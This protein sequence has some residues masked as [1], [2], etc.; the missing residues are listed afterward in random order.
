M[1]DVRI[2][3]ELLVGESTYS[4]V[5]AF[6]IRQEAGPMIN[7]LR[8]FTKDS[9]LEMTPSHLILMHRQNDLNPPNYLQA[10]KLRPGDSIFLAKNDAH[11][12][13]EP[14]QVIRIESSI[15]STEAY[16]PLTME[17]TLIVDNVLVSCYGEYEHQSLVHFVMFPLRFWYAIQ[18]YAYEFSTLHPYIQF[19]LDTSQWIHFVSYNI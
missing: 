1:R 17:G 18:S 14:I 3:D 7:Y 4:P 9:T 11:G 6:L 13:L 15:Q 5:I 10:A 12:K 16:A 19:W 2:G 8:I